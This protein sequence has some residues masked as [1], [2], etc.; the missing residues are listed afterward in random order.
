MKR[1]Q[2]RIR[3]QYSLLNIDIP[4]I[5][6][7]LDQLHGINKVD[8]FDDRATDATFITV[9]VTLS[10]LVMAIASLLK[11]TLLQIPN[12]TSFVVDEHG[13]ETA[14]QSISDEEMIL[15]ARDR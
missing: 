5:K 7:T 2:F 8:V 1:I 6:K 12:V 9:V 4:L 11:K 14:L 15:Y 13:K 10:E 3:P